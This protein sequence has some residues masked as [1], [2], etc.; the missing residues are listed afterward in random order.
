MSLDNDPTT[1]ES[2]ARAA[3]ICLPDGTRLMVH[4]GLPEPWVWAVV[5]L[6]M[7]IAIHTVRVRPPAHR[8]APPLLALDGLP[9]V[10]RLV[11]FLTT[12]PWPL[13]LLKI[14]FVAVFLMVVYA[15]L[16]GTPLPERNLATTLTWTVWW[17]L[18]VIS[19]FF[20]GTAWC[21]VCPWDTLAGWLVRQTLWRRNPEPVG[22]ERQ[23]PRWLRNVWP[24]FFLFVGLTWLELGAGVTA[25]P[26]TTAVL[27]LV[28]V[29]LA[30]ASLAVFK[31]K[32]FCRYFCPVGRTLG[33]YAQLA[34]V[35]L[36]PLQQSRCGECTSLECYN[37]SDI[38]EPCP[39]ALTM[40]RFSQNTYCTSCGACVLSCP[41][42]NV[43][44]H[45]RPMA[46]EAGLEARPHWDESWFMLAL[47]SLTTFHGVTMLPHWELF[48][49][50]FARMIGDSGQ[51][52]FGFTVGMLLCL[53]LPVALYGLVIRLTGW[54]SGNGGCFRRLFNTLSFATLPVAFAYH[55]AHNLNH[56]SREGSGLSSVFANPLGREALPMGYLEKYGRLMNPLLPE[57]LLQAAQAGLMVLGFWLA[58]RILLN[59]GRG[60]DGLTA[61]RGRALL[62]MLMF[63]GGMSG[64]NLWLLARE[65]VMRL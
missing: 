31:R 18:V 25:S 58:T 40:G 20:L 42:E 17:S 13:T 37:G 33:F 9:L 22:L 1:V 56:F 59:R 6:L 53:L 21:S 12:S 10:G 44:W 2:G 52:L 8:P 54:L 48:L 49:R 34:P 55:L 32:S 39:T 24:A 50:A 35:A 7:A 11:R 51:L 38:I 62:P 29:V 41:E 36:R 3:E 4:A 60:G 27:A 43:S 65:M 61:I 46:S 16:F 15:G 23:P 45:L 47:F 14:G 28:M 64:F 63:I 19:I 57:W 5:I 26:E 30:T